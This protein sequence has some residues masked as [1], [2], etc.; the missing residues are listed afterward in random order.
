MIFLFK[1]DI[2]KIV[3]PNT[4]PRKTAVAFFRKLHNHMINSRGNACSLIRQPKTKVNFYNYL[5]LLLR[6]FKALNLEAA[7][8]WPSMRASVLVSQGWHQSLISCKFVG[9]NNNQLYSSLK[10]SLKKIHCADFADKFAFWGLFHRLDDWIVWWVQSDWF[11]KIV[12][13]C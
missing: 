6:Q 2:C 9:Q 12:K 11:V 8:D 10:I 3:P 5:W 7:A 1:I 13:T 4:N